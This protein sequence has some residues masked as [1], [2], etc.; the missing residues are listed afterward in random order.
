[1][2]S[3]V[4]RLI[5]RGTV[6]ME[7][8]MG[9]SGCKRSMRRGKHS[10]VMGATRVAIVS[11]QVHTSIQRPRYQLTPVISLNKHAAWSL[12]SPIQSIPSPTDA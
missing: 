6:E 5:Q 2:T 8:E 7:M 12:N 10:E 3:C 1:M 11:T 9:A 4:E